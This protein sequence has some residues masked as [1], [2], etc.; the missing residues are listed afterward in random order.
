MFEHQGTLFPCEGDQVVAQV[1]WG[2][3]GVSM[4]QDIQKSS[5]CEPGQLAL[6]VPV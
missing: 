6:D 1:A 4:L 5:R 3:Y 2:G